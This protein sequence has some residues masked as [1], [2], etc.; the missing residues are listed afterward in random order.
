MKL[1]NRIKHQARGFIQTQLLSHK[2]KF[3]VR[4]ENVSGVGWKLEWRAPHSCVSQFWIGAKLTAPVLAI[5]REPVAGS[6]HCNYREI[7]TTTQSNNQ[8]TRLFCRR[9]S[10]SFHILSDR[11]SVITVWQ[12]W[13]FIFLKYPL[14]SS[15]A[16]M[17]Y[18]RDFFNKNNNF[19]F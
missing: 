12:Y 6:N 5:S 3:V 4:F 13:F 14:H 8:P 9:S 16:A 2:C 1:Q 17:C 10:F 15:L 19:L 18:K 11:L 7:K